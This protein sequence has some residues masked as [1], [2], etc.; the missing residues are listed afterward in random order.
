MR[1]RLIGLSIGTFDLFHAGHVNFLRQ[2]RSN[3]EEL[4]V[5]LNEDR[6]AQMYKRKPI[7]TL[8]ERFTMADSCKYVDHVMVNWSGQDSKPVI[9]QSGA[10]LLFHGD[11]WK[12]SSLMA[13]LGI[14][15]EWLIE[16]EIELAYIPYTQGI[17]SSN[18]E[19][20]VKAR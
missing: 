6:F 13:Q 18:L 1:N 10:S 16:K 17:S 19:E 20:R 12:D 4:V 7:L 11:D 5:A 14:D 9:L 3:C 15:N 2:C 8:E